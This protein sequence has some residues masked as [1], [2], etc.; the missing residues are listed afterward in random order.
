MKQKRNWKLIIGIILAAILVI[1]LGGTGAAYLNSS[2]GDKTPSYSVNIDAGQNRILIATQKTEFKDAVMQ[3]ITEHF[4]NQNI[5]I[6]VIDVRQLPDIDAAEWDKIVIFSA[7]KM[8]KFHPGIVKFL[9]GQNN[10]GKI[11]MYNTSG[12]TVMSSDGIDTVTSASI[13]PQGAVST[14]INRI[15]K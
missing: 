9:E 11:F 12:G 13:N 5:F 8:Y 1:I 6:S 14:I 3:A 15:E 10:T 7:I 4:E 2:L